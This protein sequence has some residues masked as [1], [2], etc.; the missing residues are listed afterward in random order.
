MRVFIDYFS[1]TLDRV[2]LSVGRSSSFV[3]Y[4]CKHSHLIDG[5]ANSKTQLQTRTTMAMATNV[6]FSFLLSDR[7][8]RKIIPTTK[9]REKKKKKEQLNVFNGVNNFFNPTDGNIK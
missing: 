3:L 4:K 2:C 9:E 1:F 6:C 5:A 7:Y 8:T